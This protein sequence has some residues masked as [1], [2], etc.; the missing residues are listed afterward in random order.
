MHHEEETPKQW[1]VIEAALETLTMV[2]EAIVEEISL[3]QDFQG[4]VET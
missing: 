3:E 2:D 4:E 1:E